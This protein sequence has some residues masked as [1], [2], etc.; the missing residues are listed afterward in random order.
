M[1]KKIYIIDD[2]KDLTFMLKEGLELEGHTCVTEN[3]VEQAL[4]NL[5]KVKPDIILLDL[6]FENASGFA[7]LQNL[8]EFLEDIPRPAI[9]IISG[10]EYEEVKKFAFSLGVNGYIPKPFTSRDIHNIVTT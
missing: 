8:D 7:F 5:T 2:N 6:G 10:Y 3:S 4:V 1:T 9:F